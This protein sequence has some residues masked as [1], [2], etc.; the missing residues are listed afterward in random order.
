MLLCYR[1][2]FLFVH[3]AKTGGTSVRAALAPLPPARP[4]A[5][6]AVGLQPP[7]RPVAATGSA[8]SSRATR[9][10]SPRRRCCRRSSTTGLFKFA[11]VR[12]P[13]DLQVSSWH[14]LRRE[15]PQ[16]VAGCADFDGFPALK[17]DPQ[18]AL[19]VP[20]RHLDRAAGGLRHRPA[21]AAD[22]GLHRPLRAPGSG[23]R[24]TSASASASRPPPLPH[25]RQARRRATTTGATT[26]T[27]RPNWWP[28]HFAAD[29]ARFGYAFDDPAALVGAERPA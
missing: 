2:N 26:P 24:R 19:A 11:F 3:I 7:Q 25:R 17:L 8:S 6:A 5:G 21:R 4:L 15:R 12:N 22:R 1:H 10:P 13:W 14:H 27:K 18:R 29:I 28:D 9:R 23:L 16:L 20:P